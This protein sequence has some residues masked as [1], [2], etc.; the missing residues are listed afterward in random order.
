MKNGVKREKGISPARLLTMLM[1]P[2]T[3]PPGAMPLMSAP[4]PLSSSIRSMIWA[5]TWKADTRP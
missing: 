3:L 4:G 1:P 5:G 2:P